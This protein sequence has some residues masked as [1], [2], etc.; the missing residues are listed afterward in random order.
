MQTKQRQRHFIIYGLAE[1]D[2]LSTYVHVGR[3]LNDSDKPITENAV[4]LLYPAAISVNGVVQFNEFPDWDRYVNGEI[5][6]LSQTNSV[7]ESAQNNPSQQQGRNHVPQ[8]PTNQP[9]TVIEK[10]QTSSQQTIPRL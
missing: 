2:R 10:G 8:P 7:H 5:K 9:S 4:K 3:F 1:V 6:P